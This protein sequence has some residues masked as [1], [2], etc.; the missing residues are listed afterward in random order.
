[1]ITGSIISGNREYGIE[2]ERIQASWLSA[3][4][5]GKFVE[6]LILTLSYYHVIARSAVSQSPERSE[7]DEAISNPKFPPT[8]CS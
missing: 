1:M 6:D 4:E 7:G 5:V 2:P 3:S 8:F